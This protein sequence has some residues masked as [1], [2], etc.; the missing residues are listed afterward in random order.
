MLYWAV[1]VGGPTMSVIA[2]QCPNIII[3][4]VDLNEERVKNWN[5]PNLDGLPIYEPGLKEIV[6]KCRNKNLFF[7]I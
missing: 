6:G 1:Y 4:V 2:K 7:Q 3:N 5:N